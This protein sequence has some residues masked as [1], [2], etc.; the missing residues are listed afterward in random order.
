MKKNKI[1]KKLFISKKEK[2]TLIIMIILMYEII[3]TY[4]HRKKIEKYLLLTI[5]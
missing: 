2:K 4:I 3:N 1:K 5:L